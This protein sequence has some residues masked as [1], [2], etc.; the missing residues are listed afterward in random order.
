[1]AD[2]SGLLL[3]APFSSPGPLPLPAP[4]WGSCP[5]A[6]GASLSTC[7]ACVASRGGSLLMDR[8]PYRGGIRTVLMNEQQQ[9]PQQQ[10][11]QQQQQ[12]HIFA[13]V[14]TFSTPRIYFEAL[15]LTFISSLPLLLSSLS[16]H[17]GRPS[18]A[19]FPGFYLQLSC[20]QTKYLLRIWL[21]LSTWTLCQPS[22]SSRR[23]VDSCS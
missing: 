6:G 16:G 12:Q 19:S 11:Q 5:T 3:V 23:L 14:I 15:F 21:V 4:I 2:C 22:K 7:A 18:S 9:Q 20:T 10:Q 17:S 1:M 8:A 13:L